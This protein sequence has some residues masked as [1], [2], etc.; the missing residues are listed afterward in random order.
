MTAPAPQ[1]STP[2]GCLW[3]LCRLIPNPCSL[4]DCLGRFSLGRCSGCTTNLK[5]RRMKTASAFFIAR[6]LKALPLPEIIS[7]AYETVGKRRKSMNLQGYTLCE[8]MDGVAAQE[9]DS[10]YPKP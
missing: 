3:P 5:G 6:Q 10:N 7:K 1:T 2:S 4:A 8:V 9:I